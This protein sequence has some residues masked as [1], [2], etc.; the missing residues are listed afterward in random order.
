MAFSGFSRDAAPRAVSRAAP[1]RERLEQLAASKPSRHVFAAQALRLIAD[2]AAVRTAVLLGYDRVWKRLGI[3]TTLG[4]DR[5]AIGALAE[6]VQYGSWQAPLQCLRS[7]RIGV[8]ESA[9]E[10]RSVP[11]ELIEAAGGSFT[12]ATVPLHHENLPAGVLLL[13]A[14]TA[15]GFP[16]SLLQMLA[17]LAA[18]CAEALVTLPDDAPAAAGAAGESPEDDEARFQPGGRARRPSVRTLPADPPGAAPARSTGPP[19]GRDPFRARSPAADAGQDALARIAQLEKDLAAARATAH[20]VPLL[21]QE[22]ERLDGQHRWSVAAGRAYQAEAQRL[23]TALDEA[24]RRLAERAARVDELGAA[25]T[26]LRRQLERMELRVDELE[27]AFAAAETARNEALSERDRLQAKLAETRLELGSY[28]SKTAEVEEARAAAEAARRQ[29]GVEL[30]HART[31]LA[32]LRKDAARDAQRAEEFEQSWKRVEAERARL[33]AEL[34]RLGQELAGVQREQARTEGMFEHS[35]RL[36]DQTQAEARALAVDLAQ[37][38]ARLARLE[39]AQAGV[40]HLEAEKQAL[41][42]AQ[43]QLERAEAE[44]FALQNELVEA[45]ARL[46]ALA[47]EQAADRR[48]WS[49]RVAEL[50][51]ALDAREAQRQELRAREAEWTARLAELEGQR[52]TLESEIEQQRAAHAEV[53]AR[54]EEL[55]AERLRLGEELA[56]A[57]SVSEEALEQMRGDLEA[58][59]ENEQRLKGRVELLIRAEA[60]RIKVQRECE[61]L[62][63]ALGEAERRARALEAQVELLSRG[64][65]RPAAAAEPALIAAFEDELRERLRAATAHFERLDEAEDGKASLEA[66][67]RT[68]EAVAESA[69]MAGEAT[70]AEDGKR[71]AELLGEGEPLEPDALAEA[72]AR[73]HRLFARAELE[74][75]AVPVVLRAPELLDNVDPEILAA[76]SVEAAEE[77]EACEQAVL[78][79]EQQADDRDALYEIF[80]RFHTL[81]GAAGAVGLSQVARQLHHGETLLEAVSKGQVSVP[82]DKLGD[83]CLKLLDS[84]GALLKQAR[85]QK[86]DPRK[87]LRNV[88]QMIHL[89]WSPPEQ[90]AAAPER[91][92]APAAAPV[93]VDRQEAGAVVR[94]EAAQL[95]ALMSE[96]ARLVAVRG[97]LA[98]E[99]ARLEELAGALPAPE[100]G[101]T[102]AGQLPAI[103]AALARRGAELAQHC[104]QLERQIAQLRLAPL[105]SVLRRLVRP[106]RDAARQENKQVEIEILNGEVQVDRAVLDGLYG[107]LLHVVRN[108]VAHG[109]EA[110]EVREKNGKQR[111]GLIRIGA[112]RDGDR[113]VLAVQDDGAGI[114]FERV[115]SKA[116]RVGLVKPDQTLE[117]EQLIALLF[118][119]GFSTRDSAS[120]LA[121]RG[122]G[123]DVVAREIAALGG[124]IEIDSE[125]GRGTTFRFDLPAVI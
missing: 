7:Q 28:L 66:L 62:T 85:R 48:Q 122:V 106:V 35:S 63:E 38:R 15:R 111:T 65:P 33:E 105:D 32:R 3:L 98:A 37:T 97:D 6:I 92:G 83:F 59:R 13:F 44:R 27:E 5:D 64:Q 95:G 46:R 115:L 75:P 45:R 100:S 117:R 103:V 80:R 23:K 17:Q 73:L 25:S 78:R 74:T 22:I 82:G 58:A 112:L 125:A 90:G 11:R 94:V 53:S 116:R 110:P 120:D 79:L 77:M 60:Q 87:I 24:E 8:I 89:L 68:F 49:A 56:S 18:V 10:N 51:K 19:S 41:A 84:V 54:L 70:L 26:E 104:A 91:K 114:D 50:E 99:I 93:G 16:D 76:F 72:D 21:E 123:M 81:K 88:E 69:E 40:A 61:R 119:P 96:V 29:L 71:L 102:S 14:P 86:V 47:E 109:I 39:E 2:F 67:R 36:L 12:I 107:P 52:A 4:M 108:A 42:S 1:F 101:G 43:L 20:L 113:V 121:G 9:H 30:L 57:R 124:S 34:S 118:Q 55:E 31:E